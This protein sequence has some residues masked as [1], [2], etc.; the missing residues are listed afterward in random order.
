ME[1][2]KVK[3]D[4]LI[5]ELKGMIGMLK[6]CPKTMEFH[7]LIEFCGI[8]PRFMVAATRYN[9]KKLEN[10]PKVTNKVSNI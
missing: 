9:I 5:N 7:T 8:D 10:Q 2:V 4:D 3:R 6:E 1:F